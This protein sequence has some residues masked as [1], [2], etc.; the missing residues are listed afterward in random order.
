MAATGSPAAAATGR[1]PRRCYVG[2]SMTLALRLEPIDRALALSSKLFVAI[3]PL[4]I[5]VSALVPST[6]NFGP[7][8]VRGFHLTGAGARATEALFATDSQIQATVDLLG[9]VIVLYSVLSYA[10]GLQRLYVDAW[11][12]KPLGIEGWWRR[13]LWSGGYTLYLAAWTTLQTLDR[14]AWLGVTYAT[15][16]LA[17]SFGLAFWGPWALVGNR[18]HWRRLLPTA[19]VTASA[20]T[21]FKGLSV[22]FAPAAFTTAA[23]RYG[24]I[25]IA[26]V[27]LSWLFLD[28][29]VIVT[30]AIVTVARDR[31]RHG[32]AM[33]LAIERHRPRRQRRAP[34]TSG[35]PA[36]VR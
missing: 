16:V 12:L 25:G 27:I 18:I 9:I 33:T 7:S 6:G 10:R 24:M 1:S 13:A 14:H 30:A 36:P 11:E 15:S 23:H 5:I 19:A 31:R 17:L 2:E 20:D 26:F 34:A 35:P 3:I 28:A 4:N 8:L 29:L 22:L 21:V 32:P